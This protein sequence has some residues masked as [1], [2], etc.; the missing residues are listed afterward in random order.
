MKPQCKKET[1][2]LI[3][4]LII[5]GLSINGC[6]SSPADQESAWQIYERF[7]AALAESGIETNYAPFFSA[8]AYQDIREANEEDRPYIKEMLAYPRYFA[9]TFEHYEK[10]IASGACLT[11]NGKTP[12]GDFGS[13]S[14]E[15]LEENGRLKMNDAN[16]LYVDSEAG[17]ITQAKC[18][19]ETRA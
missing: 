7:R 8:H 4:S 14:I 19:V 2:L 17:F 10:R 12:H 1:L 11:L 15:F 18:P 9:I 16:L 13:L 6:A 3:S 5:S